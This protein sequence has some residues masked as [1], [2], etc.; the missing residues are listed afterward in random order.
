MS[1]D[2]IRRCVCSLMQI[3]FELDVFCFC[4]CELETALT[5]WQGFSQNYE[6]LAQWL[7]ETE[8]KLRTENTTRSD[9]DSKRHMLDTL[10][11]LL[12]Q[13]PFICMQYSMLYTHQMI[14]SYGQWLHDVCVL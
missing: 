4:R 13:I 3:L 7:K 11:V 5:H 6:T 1:G 9:L 14:N 2:T 8:A 10:K 12:T